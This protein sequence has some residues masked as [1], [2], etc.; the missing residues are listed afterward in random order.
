MSSWSPA[1]AN[2]AGD[3]LVCGAMAL[4]ISVPARNDREA[5]TISWLAIPVGLAAWL[6]P[7]DRE[8]GR[9]STALCRRLRRYMKVLTLVASA[10]ALLPPSCARDGSSSSGYQCSCCWRAPA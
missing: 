9:R 1:T 10:G 4:L 3:V 7:Q 5:E 6:V 2:C 8:A